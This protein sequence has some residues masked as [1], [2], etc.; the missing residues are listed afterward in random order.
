MSAKLISVNVGRPRA[1]EANGKTHQSAIWKTPVVGRV[2]VHGVNVEGDDQADR[3]VHGGPDKAVYAYAV[4]DL[5][6]WEHELGR[7]LEPGTL[8]ENLTTEGLDVTQALIGERWQVGTTE[9]EVSQPRGPC[10][11]LAHRVGDPAIV[12]TFTASLRPGAYL[13]ILRGG[14]LGASDPVRIVHRPAHGVTIR[15]A[16]RIYSQD[17]RSAERLLAVPELSRA[18]R[19]WALQAARD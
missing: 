8:G 18:W 19:E 17:R 9:L 10:W 4:E 16:S 2:R 6:Y 15:E 11:K 3:E 14:E 13:R 1:F 12:K 5:R 7:S